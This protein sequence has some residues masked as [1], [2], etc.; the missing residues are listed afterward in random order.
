MK[1]HYENCDGICEGKIELYH[2]MTAYH[3]EG[4]RNSPEDPNKDFYACEYH[5]GIY[6]DHWK[7]MWNEYYGSGLL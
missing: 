2:A 3:F 7:N 5:Y 4:V 6:E 1:C